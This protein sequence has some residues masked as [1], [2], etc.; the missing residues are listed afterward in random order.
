MTALRLA[1]PIRWPAAFV[2]PVLAGC[3]FLSLFVPFFLEEPWLIRLAIFGGYTSGVVIL[4]RRGGARVRDIVILV[5]P[6]VGAAVF[7]RY[8]T[9]GLVN[10]IGQTVAFV[11]PILVGLGIGH[12]I[13]LGT[14]APGHYSGYTDADQKVIYAFAD[15]G[16]ELDK[17]LQSVTGHDFTKHAQRSLVLGNVRTDDRD[18]L[19]VR[20]NFL[21]FAN[22]VIN[23]AEDPER[24][25][26]GR[27]GDRFL[28]SFAATVDR[29]RIWFGRWG[30]PTKP[31]DAAPTP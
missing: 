17:A 26:V 24:G 11:A 15:A 3:V 2:W 1:D 13:V 19:G 29:R 8:L 22:Y 7:F 25:D 9:D 20:S 21:A 14:I 23:K 18:W 5:G 12:W 27:L 31:A 28:D 16:R 30:R 6:A 10:D 4:L